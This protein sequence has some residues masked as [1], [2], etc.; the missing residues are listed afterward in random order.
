MTL[1]KLTAVSPVDG[2]YA[3]KT[4]ILSSYFSEYALIKYRVKV[5]IEYFIAL[6]ELPLPQL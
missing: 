5:E 2:R 1:S 6:C 3:D 4:S